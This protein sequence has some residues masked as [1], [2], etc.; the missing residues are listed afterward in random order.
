[1]DRDGALAVGLLARDAAVLPLHAD[2]MLALLG[3]A[4]VVD[5]EGP[6]R[7]GEG[8]G[9]HGAIPLPDP[10]VVPGAPVDELLK[11]LLGVLDGELR[12]PGPPPGQRLDA[13]ALPVLDPA[14]EVDGC[15]AGRPVE[16]EGLAESGGVVL[17][18]PKDLRGEF[19]GVGL[20]HTLRYEHDP[21]RVRIR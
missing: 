11:G 8:R 13:L 9:H 16:S 10:L 3:G 1:M 21:V 14:G 2:R 19:G 6:L 17:Q 12:R 7:V 15:P 4:G 18:P 20:A 5:D